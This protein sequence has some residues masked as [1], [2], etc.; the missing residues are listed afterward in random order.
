MGLGHGGGRVCD[1]A[2]DTEVHHLDCARR[3]QHDICR[4]NIAVY[5]AHPMAVRQRVQDPLGDSGSLVRL[6]DCHFV[7][8]LAQGA[9]FDVLHHDVGQGYLPATTFGVLVLARVID[10]DD[11]GVVEP[12]RRLG[13]AAEPGQKRWVAGQ[14]RAEH[15][16]RHSAAEPGVVTRVDFGH[17][18]AT[19]QLSDLIPPA[20][21]TSCT[22]HCLPSFAL[23]WPLALP[24][25]RLSWPGVGELPVGGAISVVAPVLSVALLLFEED[26]PVGVAMGVG[27]LLLTPGAA[28]AAKAMNAAAAPAAAR[29]Q[30]GR[31]RDRR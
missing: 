20:Q 2:G 24:F 25:A 14:V 6:H 4:L 23:L 19:N 29:S 11:G 1:G 30:A 5:D 18:A 15:L 12:C 7:E 3:G 8:D 27:V 22:V 16:D 31:T 26:G 9:A 28:K 10:G 13:F 17:S 21:Q